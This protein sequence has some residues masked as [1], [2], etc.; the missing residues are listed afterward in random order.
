[1]AP[2]PKTTMHMITAMN[3]LPRSDKAPLGVVGNAVISGVVGIAVASGPVV[4]A[5][6]VAG[7]T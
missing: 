2:V 6:V 5:T 4:G 7:P 1:M 3:E